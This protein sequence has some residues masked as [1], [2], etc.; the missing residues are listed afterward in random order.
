VAR[1]NR[2]EPGSIE[3]P[4]DAAASMELLSFEV[5]GNE[6]AI[7]IQCVREIRR[8][9]DATT[10]PGAPEYVLGVI[11]LR[12]TVLPVVDLARRLDLQTKA[13]DPRDVVIVVDDDRR[14]VG[15]R[16]DTVSDILSLAEAEMTPAPSTQDSHGHHALLG[17]SLR[18]DKMLRILNLAALLE[19]SEGLTDDAT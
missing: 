19:M 17:L 8:W 7:D 10:L 13:P 11:N 12:G 2:S 6:F 15:L 18:D 1:P 16:V 3:E 9:S 5:S 4:I 14:V